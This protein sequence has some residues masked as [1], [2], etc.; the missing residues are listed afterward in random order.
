M[1]FGMA[2]QSGGALRL[3][4]QPGQGTKVTILLRKAAATDGIAADDGADRAGELPRAARHGLEVMIVDD[5][6]DV[7]RVMIETLRGLGYAAPGFSRG[8]AA[9]RVMQ[10][11]RPDL[12]ILDFVMPDL[13]GADVARRAREL[14]PDLHILFA[15]GYADSTE[16]DAVMDDRSAMLR[17]PFEAADLARLVAACLKRSAGASQSPPIA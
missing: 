17:K 10:Q 8:A 1:A 3:Q 4:S 13:N 15:S 12:L 9:L 2:R 14:Y 7:R 5:D 6:D 16:L 11:R